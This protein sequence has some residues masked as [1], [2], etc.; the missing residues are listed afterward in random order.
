MWQPTQEAE[1]TKVVVG[2]DHTEEAA[3]MDSLGEQ[4]EFTQMG[5]HRTLVMCI[6]SMV[7]MLII[8][9]GHIAARG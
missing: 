5:P 8:V 3:D 1:V 9:T 2:V 6:G 7:N 4:Q